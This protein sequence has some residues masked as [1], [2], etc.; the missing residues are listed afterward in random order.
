MELYTA[1]LEQN[2][3]PEVISRLL[4]VIPPE[5][6]LRIRSLFGDRDR[7]RSLLADLV[8]RHAIAEKLN[9]NFND[10]KVSA[11]S[12][13][14]PHSI[15]QVHFNVSHSEDYIGCVLSDLSHVG[16]DIEKVRRLNDAV[17]LS[18]CPKVEVD[19]INKNSSHKYCSFFRLWTAKESYAKYENIPMDECCSRL[20]TKASSVDGMLKKYEQKAGC[21][22]HQTTRILPGYVVS[23][24]TRERENIKIHEVYS[25]SQMHNLAFK[26]IWRKYQ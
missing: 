23:I 17:I 15:P 19:L 16:V 18:I 4:K 20:V 21:F 5:K 6:S 10:V 1:K 8:A 2:I 9:L 13:G 7:R 24:C 14:K 22:F 26:N 11:G 25:E 3:D 12:R